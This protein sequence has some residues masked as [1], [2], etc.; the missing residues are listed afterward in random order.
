MCSPFLLFRRDLHLSQQSPSGRFDVLAEGFP[1]ILL[2][3]VLA[4]LAVGV[5]ALDKMAKR[6][7]TAT[8][9]K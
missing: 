7:K 2:L 6:K 5:V 4:G 9:W 8:L 3:A 1:K